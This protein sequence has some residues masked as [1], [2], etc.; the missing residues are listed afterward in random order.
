[1]NNKS[2]VI[3]NKPA[4]KRCDIC[5]EYSLYA[6]ATH[7]KGTHK[8]TSDEYASMYGE[9]RQAKRSPSKRNIKKITC[10]ICNNVYSSVGMHVHLRDTHNI[11][12]NE[13]CLTYGEYRPAK[14]RQLEYE[15]RLI[16]MPPT[17]KHMCLVCNDK[18]ASPKLLGHHITSGH[19]LTRK[20]YIINHVFKG[21][22][23]K[24]KCGCGEYVKILLKGNK[25]AREYKSGHNKSTK[26]KHKI[27]TTVSEYTSKLQSEKIKEYYATP[28]ELSYSI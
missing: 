27:E 11:S 14:L 3:I 24:C 7:I 5:N 28:D 25:F 18:F 13:Y 20:D 12:D 16:N 23:P 19:N 15:N 8:L 6:F 26:G 1:M 4:T 9:F 21:I 10:G 17:E 2:R 22:I